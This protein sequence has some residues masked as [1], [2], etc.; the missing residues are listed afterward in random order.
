MIRDTSR[1]V[2]TQIEARLPL[3]ATINPPHSQNGRSPL[4][5]LLGKLEHCGT[6]KP[7]AG[8]NRCPDDASTDK[9]V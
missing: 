1:P 6:K 3:P 7:S 5:T 9:S 8:L 2:G 4:Q